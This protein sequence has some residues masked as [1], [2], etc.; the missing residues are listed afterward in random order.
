MKDIKVT[1]DIFFQYLKHIQES[2]VNIA[3][4]N[5]EDDTNIEELL[6]DITYKTVYDVMELIDGYMCAEV[7]LDLVDKLT[8]KSISTNIELHDK[9]ANYLK[10][11]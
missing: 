4:A 8:N 3:L 10:C 11:Y 9:C 6:Y 5:Y 2:N 7:K 1:Q